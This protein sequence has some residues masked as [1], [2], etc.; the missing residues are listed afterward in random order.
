M[1][2]R[3]V[4]ISY[5]KLDHTLY[6]INCGSVCH[7]GPGS[8]FGGTFQ[9]AIFADFNLFFLPVLSRPSFT[10]RMDHKTEQLFYFLL[11]QV[12]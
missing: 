2:I 12:L 6:S 7:H 10:S 5:V 8:A 3:K 1:T 9:Y 11:V 4:L